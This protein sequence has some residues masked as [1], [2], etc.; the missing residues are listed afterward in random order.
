[1]RGTFRGV[2]H[3]EFETGPRLP[4][5][6]LIA[7]VLVAAF[8]SW[9]VTVLL[10]LAVIAAVLALLLTAAFL[11]LSRRNDRDAELLAERSAALHAEMAPRAAPAAVENHYHLH[12][13]A[14]TDASGVNWAAIPVRDAAETER[15]EA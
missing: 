7:A 12:L 2:V 3:G 8:L 9:L 4:V 10:L 1:M 14:G 15:N 11:L 6:P 5:V 13:P